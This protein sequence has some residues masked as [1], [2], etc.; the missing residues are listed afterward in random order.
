[1]AYGNNYQEKDGDFSSHSLGGFLNNLRL[2]PDTGTQN[3]VTVNK[4][5]NWDLK[6]RRGS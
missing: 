1:M 3:R 5:R 4:P 6:A 2:E